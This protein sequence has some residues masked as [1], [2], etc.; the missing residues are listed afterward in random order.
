MKDFNLTATITISVY[1][2]VKAHTLEEAIKIAK[3]KTPMDIV[4]TGGDNVIDNWMCDEIDG[5]P[6]DIKIIE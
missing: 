6:Y 4:P 3:D 2:I 1:T 5:E